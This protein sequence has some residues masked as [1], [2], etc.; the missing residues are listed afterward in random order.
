VTRIREFL[1]RLLARWARHGTGRLAA[2]LAFYGVFSMAPLMLVVT[3]VLGFFFGKKAVEGELY[4]SLAT[5]MGPE[6]A[7][8]VHGLAEAAWDPSA[9]AWSA[10]VGV[11]TLIWAATRLLSELQWA[12]NVVL[13][14]PPARSKV[15]GLLGGR[16]VALGVMLASGAMVLATTALS[17]FARAWLP[18]MADGPALPPALV[19]AVDDGTTVLVLT[20]ALLVLYRLLPRRRLPWRDLAVGAL[21]SAVLLAAGKH[22]FALY[23]GRSGVASAYGAAGSLV[24]LMLWL[25][26]SMS[27]LLVGAE[28]VGARA[29]PDDP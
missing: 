28:I 17:T 7:E 23:L 3:A 27:A 22:A 24:A 26:F 8:F 5:A 16:L 19:A 21:V 6:L 13:E 29:V 18:R 9:Q 11:A 4:G 15:A 10:V 1:R 14:S 2:A 25:Q 20:P 12:L